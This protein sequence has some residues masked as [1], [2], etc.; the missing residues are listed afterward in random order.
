MILS[1]CG[2]VR[3]AERG[4]GGRLCVRSLRP[5]KSC[6]SDQRVAYHTSR[7]WIKKAVIMDGLYVFNN[8]WSVQ[9]N[10]KQTK[11]DIDPLAD[12]RRKPRHAVIRQLL[13]AGTSI[14]ELSIQEP[15]AASLLDQLPWQVN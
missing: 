10:E 1:S 12:I 7:E 6:T 2:F 14:D 8:P 11:L 3:R 9:S 4:H 5:Q 15:R 13:D